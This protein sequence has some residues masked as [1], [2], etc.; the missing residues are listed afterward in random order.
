[1]KILAG[2]LPEWRREWHVL[3][4][5]TP[6]APL[7]NTWDLAVLLARAGEGS[8]VLAVLIDEDTEEQRAE[9]QKALD[10]AR[11]DCANDVP[12]VGFVTTREV[13]V[14]ETNNFIRDARIDILIDD[15]GDPIMQNLDRSTCAVVGV[16]GDTTGVDDNDDGI[17]SIL[18]PT[19]GGP[20]STY[21]LSILLPLTPDTRVTALYVAPEHL[22]ENEVALGYHR[23]H[24]TIDFIDGEGRIDT[25]LITAPTIGAGIREAAGDYDLVLIGASTESS[26]DK[27]IFGNIPDELVRESKKPVAVMREPHDPIA[28]FLGEV[29]FRLQR[30]IPRLNISER[31]ETYVRIR[32]GARPSLD[33]YVLISLSAIIAALGLIAN[34]AA[35]VIGAMLVAPLMSPIVGTGLAMVLGDIRFLRLA[36][37]AVFRGALMALL[38]STVVGLI[39]IGDPLTPELM[40]RTQPSM[41]DLLIALFSG[42][43]AAYALSKSNAA[44][45]LPGV[46]IAAALVPPLSTAGVA[47]TAGY[48]VESLGA[49]LL[50]ITNLVAI[51]VAAAIVFIILGFRP[52]RAQKERKQIRSRSARVAVISL[53]VVSAILLITTYLLNQKN[54]D[55]NRI[56][57]VTEQ[58]LFEV[59]GAEL[60]EAEI[61]EFDNGHLRLDIVARSTRTISYQEVQDL[62]AA[63]GEQLVAEGII[64]EIEMTMTVIRVTELDPLT[65]PTPTPGP[66]PTPAEVE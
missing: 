48:Y 19:S 33:F 9:A 5:R 39:Q 42:M 62:Q 63:I 1:M 8:V 10:D 53:L 57:E 66:S 16:R 25:E 22:G 6:Q 56:H 18:V 7:A 4:A 15:I 35:V 36:L 17:N 65:P 55:I 38:L 47:F 59:I 41:L 11:E 52:T 13:Y 24:E 46:A 12:L 64:E 27:V 30:V 28:H 44:A 50:F 31:T 58:A 49:L 26:I 32:R 54:A 20:N 37:G 23:L 40:A 51:T 61:V 2:E 3:Y 14:Q 43:A 60:E 34:S 21:A 29:S 45:A